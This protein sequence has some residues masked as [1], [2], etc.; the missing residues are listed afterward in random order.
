[1]DPKLKCKTFTILNFT[2]ILISFFADVPHLIKLARTH[3]LQKGFLLPPDINSHRD[4]LKKSDFEKIVD[5]NKG[6]DYK[7]NFRLSHS[8]LNLTGSQSQRVRLACQVFSRTNAKS[9]LHFTRLF[10]GAAGIAKHNAVLLFNNWWVFSKQVIGRDFLTFKFRYTYVC[11]RLEEGWRQPV[12]SWT[13]WLKRGF[14]V[15]VQQL[16]L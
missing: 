2:C 8:H 10:P 6:S 15:L 3:C 9:F 11:N 7:M 1:M 12:V 5:A 14:V 16:P 4:T 13:F